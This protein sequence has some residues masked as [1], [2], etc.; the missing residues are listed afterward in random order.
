MLFRKFLAGGQV[1]NRRVCLQRLVLGNFIGLSFLFK[2]DKKQVKV[3]YKSVPKFKSS[4]YKSVK[5]FFGSFYG[6]SGDIFNSQ[7]IQKGKVLSIKAKLSLDKKTAWSEYVYKDKSAF[8][9]CERAWEKHCP[10]DPVRHT[11]VSIV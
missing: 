1:M 11:V 6:G 2:P 10:E 9:E 3:I 8:I 4:S 7:N 5:D